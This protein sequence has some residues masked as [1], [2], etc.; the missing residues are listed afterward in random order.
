V[1]RLIESGDFTGKRDQTAI[2]YPEK[3]P[4]RVLLVG[5]GTPAEITRGAIRRGASVAARR[6]I[7]LGVEAMAF[8]LAHETHGGV[9]PHSVGQVVVE[10][11]IQG[12][13][14]FTELKE[15]EKKQ[16]LRTLEIIATR[17]ERGDVEAG[18][19]IG[20]AIAEGQQLARN[21]QALPGNV[22]T[23]TY[24]AGVARKLGRTYGY[25]VTVLGRE[26]MDKAGMG[27]LLAVAQGSLQEPQ[28]MTLE[29]KG[30]GRRQ[31]AVFVGK[32]VTFDSGGISI[33]PAQDMDEMKYDMSGAAAV[34]G[35]FETLAHLKP[36]LN[37]VGIVPATENL[38]SG[39][40]IKPGDIVRGM[41]GKTIEIANTD[42]E[43]RLI[44]SDAL[45]YARR[46]KPACVIDAATLTGAVIVGLGHHATGLMGNDDQLVD[47]V[48]QAGDLAGERCWPL[49]LWDEY[50]EQIAS[51][52]ADVKNVGGRPAGSITAGWFLREFV[53]GFP[54]AHLDIA[55]TAY[56]DSDRA[57][58]PK[59]PAGVGVRLF[60][61]FVLRRAA[62]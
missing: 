42:A 56:T 44:L 31:P 9:P 53:D 17:E 47:E 18:R 16:R 20:A 38:P 11:V 49:P 19:R 6:A 15:V 43:G 12:A 52:I 14:Q 2:V 37:V 13:W 46:F 24:L 61:E 34:L 51:T 33:K 3:R 25:K 23:P 50:R 35:L 45:A 39:S 36:K 55:G 7:D 58:L 30:A 32:G 29:Y 5:L 4:T 27:A 8:H 62:G 60:A 54:W 28:F 1:S 10:G 59:G 48:R 26:Q 40:A 22:C 57:D 41:L 21:L